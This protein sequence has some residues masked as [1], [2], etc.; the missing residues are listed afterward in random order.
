MKG[1]ALILVTGTPGTGKSVMSRL[2]AEELGCAHIESSTLLV[3]GKAATRDLTGRDAMVIVE[4]KA[5]E[6]IRGFIGSAR[7]ACYVVS[8]L[9][10]SL[11]LE[12]LEENVALVILLRSDPRILMERLSKRGWGRAKIVENVLSEAFNVVAEE[13]LEWS[14]CVVEVETSYKE[15]RLVL[16]E[17][18]EKLEAWSVG[19]NIDWMGVNPEI[20]EFVTSLVHEMDLYKEGLGV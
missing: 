11:W 5:K 3:E 9:H 14:D 19:I 2:L 7:E 17:V 18:F 20:V 8:T 13:L 15:P 4:D 16:E 10:P 12:T 6:V 1:P